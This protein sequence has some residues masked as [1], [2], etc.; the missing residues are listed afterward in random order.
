ML[1]FTGKTEMTTSRKE[2][3]YLNKPLQKTS[4]INEGAPLT[5]VP[6][7][8]LQCIDTETRLPAKKNNNTVRL[9]RDKSKKEHI[10]AST[11]V[12][13]KDCFSQ[14]TIF[15]KTNFFVLSPN[16]PKKQ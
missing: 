16:L 14:G 3:R 9:S 1:C 5:Q 4:I 15:M 7:H 11:I 6:I 2:N 12:T 13:F 8:V 10:S